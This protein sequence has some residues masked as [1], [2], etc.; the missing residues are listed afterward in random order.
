MDLFKTKTS[1]SKKTILIIDDEDDFCYFIK[2]NLEQTGTFEVLTANNGADG[3]EMAK[4]YQPD[5]VLLDI[6]MP[7]MT[8]TQVAEILRNDKATKD[9]PIIFVTA[10]VKRGEVG[11]RDYQF[12]G[13]YFVFKPVKLDELINEIGAKLK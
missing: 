5:L 13:N 7:N 6:I 9:I 10:I 1:A 8:G 11:A 12:G 2:L 4:R 3:I